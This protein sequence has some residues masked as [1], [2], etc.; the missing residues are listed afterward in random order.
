MLRVRGVRALLPALVLLAALSAACADQPRIWFENQRDDPVTI[1]ID[2]DRLIILW[3]H[4]G[5][6]LPY[7]TAA[8]AWP[9][10]VDVATYYGGQHLW[11][12]TLDADDLVRRHWLFYVRP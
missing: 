11:A 3:P 7:S 10:R 4:T 1:S 6:F 12:E 2:G 9:R 5:Q 8:W